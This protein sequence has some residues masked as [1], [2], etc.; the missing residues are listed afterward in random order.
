M[1]NEI[2]AQKLKYFIKH[3]FISI[4]QFAFEKNH[5]TLICLYC[6]VD[7]WLEAINESEIVG[8]CFLDIQKCFDTINHELLLEKLRKYG[9]VDKELTWFRNYLQDRSQAVLCNGKLSNTV[10]LDIG[11]P[12]GSMLGPFLFLVFI[13]DL[14]QAISD[15]YNN[16]FADDPCLYTIRK[17]V[18]K[19]QMSLQKCV[20][21]ADECK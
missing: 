15:G 6:V 18:R 9:V 12:Q 11:A 13:N 16:M 17:G 2:Q 19:V 14:S 5:S 20:T 21:N 1:V 8:I 3:D 4:D 7:D 10:E